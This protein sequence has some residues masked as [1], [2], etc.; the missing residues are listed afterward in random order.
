MTKKSKHN[1]SKR[2][3]KST[4]KRS[5]MTG[6]NSL[7]HRSF[8]SIGNNV[9]YNTVQTLTVSTPFQSSA[10]VA[11]FTS[12]PISLNGFDQVA[13]II[14][15]YDQYRFM[16]ADYEFIPLY[17]GN[18]NVGFTADPGLFASV[19]DTTDSTTLTSFAAATDYSTC[20]IG[21]S[22]HP[23][24]HR[25]IP[26]CLVGNGV[27]ASQQWVTTASNTLA[28]NGVK[29]A[30]TPTVPVLGMRLIIRVQMQ[31]RNLR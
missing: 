2:R 11:T 29:T 14:A 21:S 15:L 5:Q 30:W 18:T 19:V 20:R 25:F 8:P 7:S 4:P 9:P 12:W 31:F 23:H 3:G 27:L 17:N 22:T 28:F 26:Q 16:V 10:S 24:R 1:S 13:S 6:S